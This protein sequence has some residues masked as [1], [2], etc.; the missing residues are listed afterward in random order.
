MG[1]RTKTKKKPK[2]LQIPEY[3]K[4]KSAKGGISASEFKKEIPL[5]GK[6]INKLLGSKWDHSW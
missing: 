1:M 4:K 5:S 6:E 2:V 3:K